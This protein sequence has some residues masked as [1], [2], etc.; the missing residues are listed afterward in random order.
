MSDS[1]NTLHVKEAR[2][3]YFINSTIG[4]SLLTFSLSLQSATL[5]TPLYNSHPHR[6]ELVLRATSCLSNTL[7]SFHMLKSLRN[8]LKRLLTI[9]VASCYPPNTFL[10]VPTQK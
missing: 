10:Y 4:P 8:E 1:I 9:L 5:H 7:R 2:P 6:H 3:R